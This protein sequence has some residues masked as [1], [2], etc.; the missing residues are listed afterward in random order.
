MSKSQETGATTVCNTGPVD[1]GHVV[2]MYN[3]I[4]FLSF[5]KAWKELE[6]PVLNE[7]R[8]EWED[9]WSLKNWLY[10]RWDQ[11]SG[12]QRTGRVEGRGRWGN[13]QWIARQKQDALGCCWPQQGSGWHHAVCTFQKAGRKHPEYLYLK[14]TR[15][16][17]GERHIWLDVH[18]IQC[19][20]V[21]EYYMG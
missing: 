18:F 1:R 13:D 9:I 17:W 12:S 19:I 10:R 2:H 14:N 4:L 21:W 11:S 6:I 15:S 5:S 8:Q 3:G 20:C 16:V 7:I